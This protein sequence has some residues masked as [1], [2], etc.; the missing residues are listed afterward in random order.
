V[1]AAL[2]AAFSMPRNTDA[3]MKI[4]KGGKP[5]GRPPKPKS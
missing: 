2:K 4:G 3:E 1:E 5:R